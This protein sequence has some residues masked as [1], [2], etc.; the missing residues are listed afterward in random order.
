MNALGE[1]MADVRYALRMMRKSSFASA[2]I[3]LCLGFSVG[4]TGTVF[5]WT[6]SIVLQPVPV[7]ASPDRL[8]SI[9]TVTTRGDANVSYPTFRD[10]R[11]AEAKAGTRTFDALAAHGIRRFMMRMDATTEAAQAEP[12]WG[13]LTT[14]NYFDVLG[15]RPVIGR[16]F[17]ASEDSV[18]GQA[19]VVVI[20]YG[21]WQ[22]RFG[23]DP[24]VRGRHIWINNREMTIIGVAPPRFNGT[25]SRLAMDIWI[26]VTMQ[27]LLTGNPHMNEERDLRYL[28]VFGRLAPGASLE[29]A[30]AAIATDGARIA[31]SYQT[32]RDLT[33]RARTFDVG[34]VE[35]M[36]TIFTVLLGISVLVVLIVCSNVANLLL[37]RGAAREHEMAVRLAMG[38]RP[39]RIVRQLLTES[40]LL[41][42]GG[43]FVS[44]GFVAWARNALNSLTPA[45]P[46]P[47]VAET[48]IDLGV[49]LVIAAVG[50]ATIFAF[51]L[52]PALRSARVAVRASLTGGGTRGGTAH[53]GRVRGAL[54][55]AQFALSLCVLAIAGLFLRRLDELQRVDRG[56]RKPEQ[57]VLATVDYE[58]SGINND[59]TEREYTERIVQRVAALPGVTNAAAA[60]F[61]PLGF[62]GYSSA[63]VTVDGYVA[64][65]GEPMT[66][67]FNRVSSGYFETIGI[68]MRRGRPIDGTDTRNSQP[69]AVINEAFAYRF[70]TGE[71]PVGHR[72]QLDGKPFTIV[73]VVA[74]GKYEF[75]A[76]LDQPSPPF[77][78]VPYA[79]WGG[80]SIVVHARSNRDPLALVPAIQRAVS[81]VDVRLTATNPSTLEA[82]SSVP[83]LPVRLA[84]R[85]LTVLGFAA[86]VLA[87][88][89]LYAVIGYA[90]AQQRRAIG[91][92]MALGASSRKLV[93]HFVAYAARYA[94][95]GAVVGTVLTVI[96]AR[97]LAS[98]VPGSVPAGNAARIV[99]FVVAVL[100]L[101]IIAAV[102]A[103]IPASRAA[104]V[105]PTVAL[106]EE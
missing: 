63:N 62:L 6:Q 37:L 38:A 55:S 19:P 35:R 76:P 89:G 92:R 106:R 85:V 83:Y 30:N 48:D 52:A 28:D 12:V 42:A 49:V 23:A 94:G 68:A 64:R 15:V 27:P 90:V 40:F 66:F 96:I 65:P 14:A 7:V 81:D 32:Q 57:V 36:A 102:A 3:V 17:L 47:I 53:G 13:S 73:G 45:S 71:D 26:P 41:A 34:P 51:G 25:I 97:G 87:T 75:L 20:S 50:V 10:I 60:T 70:W 72:I 54:V 59:S 84:S 11:D 4:A 5:A 1:L 80:Y 29:T 39:G 67:L 9:R 2:T 21:L 43:V 58:L 56:F 31:A 93:L 99:P 101:G 82:Y 91:I 8:V 78:Y 16:G 98:N 100:S 22:R 69:V 46:L 79:Q 103:L 105:A 33:M 104:R 24:A 61:V 18:S 77:V 88:L 86:L 74:D 95:A 44:L